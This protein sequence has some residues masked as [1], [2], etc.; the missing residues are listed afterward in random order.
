M[1][2][3]LLLIICDFLLLNLLALTR[4]DA[5]VAASSIQQDPSLSTDRDSPPAATKDQD[6]VELMKLSLEDE[7]ARRDELARQLRDTAQ[8][9]QT[10]EQI[11]AQLEAEKNKLVENLGATRTQLDQQITVAK[12]NAEILAREVEAAKRD[13]GMS[14]ERVAALQRDLEHR[15]AELERER[16]NIAKLEQEQRAAREKIENL[17]V[18]V[19]V[20]EHEKTILRETAETYKTQVEAERQERLKV[21]ETTTQLAQGMGTL[22]VKSGD[23]EKEIRD[24][25]PINANTLFSEY[26]ANNVRA[27]IETTRP[28]LF[29][30]AAR[31]ADLRTIL[32]S[33]GKDA[34]AIFHASDTPFALT[35]P[36]ADISRI[37]ITFTNGDYST[38][39]GE[40][41]YLSI[42]PR[43]LVVPLTPA[44]AAGLG[45]KVYMTSLEPFKFSDAILVS[46]NSEPTKTKYEETPFKL[47]ATQPGYVQMRVSFFA[48]K[49]GDLVISK[50]G[51]LLGIMVNKD[52][53]ALVDNFLPTRTITTGENT[54]KQ[55]IGALINHLN[56]RVQSMPLKL[57]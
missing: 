25:R 40:L 27:R 57:Q 55:G 46:T 37:A 11:L 39:A 45:V 31:V 15:E 52:Y 41:H 19:K 23:L 51:E 50:S 53:C 28:G 1:N 7:Q 34:C 36:G 24:N 10:R 47:D 33:D 16:G 20:A 44:Q 30:P 49:R 32:V 38:T 9:L 35:Y 2:K 56:T 5:P 54:G 17:N 3:T 14:K 4:W 8:N 48:S 26:L 13:A 29:G 43:I 12:R 6:L 42:D 18:A 22:A 21:Q